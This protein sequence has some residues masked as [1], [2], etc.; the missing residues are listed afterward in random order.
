M[1]TAAIIAEY[2]PFHNG[3][4]H[5]LEYIRRNSDAEY[6]F[7]IMSGDYTQRGEPAVF[8][9]EARAKAALLAG[10]DAVFM[11]PVPYSTAGV[12]LFS[13]GAVSLAS[14]LG[15]DYLCFGSESGD[16]DELISAA[17][18]LRIS[19]SADSPKIKK[20]MYEGHTFAKARSLAFPEFSELLN[21]PNNILGIEYIIAGLNM[22]SSMKYITLKRE[23]AG[24]DE[25]NITSGEYQ[26]ALALRN[27]LKSGDIDSF[28]KYVPMETRMLM[29]KEANVPIFLN[30]LSDSL[31]TK[32]LF[33]PDSDEYFE[34]SES[35]YN[36][37]KN[38][39]GEYRDI[40]T[41][42]DTLK[43]KN[44]THAGIRR[45]LLHILLNLKNNAEYYK[46]VSKLTHVRLL[47]FNE[48]SSELLT[49]IG[50]VG[51]VKPITR[52]PAVQKDFNS[53]TKTVFEEDLNASTLYE[54]IRCKKLDIK[55]VHEYSKPLI[56]T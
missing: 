41:F 52:V 32:L 37:I 44:L 22:E 7:V 23:G 15:A 18:K 53:F 48:D 47:G 35:L 20:Y 55:P 56:K 4:R 5:M 30:D 51:T 9:K 36:R 16:M 43:A 45:G 39:S 50:K 46:N 31:Y 14:R 40:E 25:E 19:G 21:K 24:Y 6:I 10:A 29:E 11:L 27:L 28:K 2:N 54:Y 38:H 33:L 13:L 1:K 42:A 8:S 26:S 49:H 3:H 12:E 34:V 17:V